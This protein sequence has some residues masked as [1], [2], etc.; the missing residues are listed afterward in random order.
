MNWPL[1]GSNPQYVYQSLQLPMPKVIIDFSVN[2]N[3]FGPPDSLKRNWPQ[4]LGYIED[5]PDPEGRDL[6]EILYEKEKLPK[7]SILLGNGGAELIT[8]LA[9][10]LLG[11][12]VLLIQPTFTEYEQMC[13][14]YGCHI[15]HMV[16]QE[17]SWELNVK[18]LTSKIKKSDALFLCHPNNPMGIVYSESLLLD[19]LKVCQQQQ[20]FM[21]VDE[22]FYD[23]LDESQTLAPL[24]KNNEYLIVIRSLT[25]MYSIAGLRLGYLMAN[26]SIIRELKSYQPQW[27]VNTLALLAGKECLSDED[28]VNKTRLFIKGERNRVVKAL[29]DDGYLLSDSK[30]NFY[31]L[32]DPL[33]DQQLP[34]FLFLLKKGFVP[35]HTANY[36][37]LQG[38]WLR[39]AIKQRQE[40]DLLLEALREWKSRH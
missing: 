13:R 40:N 23:F 5:Y 18:L 20:C 36:L 2:L 35:R 7:E 38:R 22:A 28:H 19:I 14:A 6:V 32:R 29:K 25:K 9:R 17:G 3:P 39:F 21:I 8:L 34:L 33:L 26:Q 1:H 4:W 16:L 12:R 30:V 11:K 27:S 10:M 15:S 31:L 24:I 37:G